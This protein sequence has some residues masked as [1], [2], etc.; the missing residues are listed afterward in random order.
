MREHGGDWLYHSEKNGFAPLDF[1][2]NVS[3]LGIPVSVRR[4]AIQAIE[5]SDRYPDP[6]CRQLRREL[7]A[8]WKLPMEFFLCGNGAAELLFRVVLAKKP[9]HALLIAPTFSE[10]EAALRVAECKLE[11]IS[12]SEQQSFRVPEDFW[13]R[14]TPDVDIVFLCEPNNPTGLTTSKERLLRILRRCEETD[15][16]LVVDE[17]FQDFLD[18]P[19]QHT[20]LSEIAEYPQLLVVRAFTK[21]YAMAGL[22]LGYCICSNTALLKRMYDVSQPW[23]VSTIAQSAGIAALK[24]DDY[25]DRVR[26]LVREQRTRMFSSMRTLGLRVL[27]GEANFLLF[28]ARPGLKEDLWKRGILIRE[29]SNFIGLD[30]SWYRIAIRTEQENDQ[31]LYTLREVLG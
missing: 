28:Q 14:I 21:L 8:K 4:A 1:S 11:I 16:L 24:E 10:Y 19:E 22:R 3:P 27:P 30:D 25:V 29:C 31:L 17:C 18:K 20:L 13:K 26:T 23:S 5:Q 9:K 2:T 15:T 6:E 12:L 7:A